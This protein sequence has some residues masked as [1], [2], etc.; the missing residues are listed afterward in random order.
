MSI[1]SGLSDAWHRLMEDGASDHAS[2]W[3]TKIGTA[4]GEPHRAYHTLEHLELM[5]ALY[6]RHHAALHITSMERVFVLAIAFHDIVY[7]PLSKTN[8]VDSISVFRQFMAESPCKVATPSE[9]A[10]VEAMIEATI[11]HQLPPLSAILPD[12][13]HHHIGCF[14]DLDLAILGQ[15]SPMYGVYSAQIRQE[16]IAYSD[17]DFCNGRAAVLRAFLGRDTL[18][19][20]HTFQDIAEKVARANVSAELER[21][22][23]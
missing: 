2:K 15:S 18:Y 8:E 1:A 4:Y 12:T 7:D 23:R 14:L 3:W 9:A 6:Q 20:T 21:L 17:A 13:A 16:Y 11:R 5:Y 10:L 19:F 22:T